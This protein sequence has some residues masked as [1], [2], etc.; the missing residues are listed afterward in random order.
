M[1]APSRILL[2]QLFSNGDCLYATSVARQIKLDYPGCHLTWA[3][4]DYCRNIIFNNPFID[5]ILVIEKI[6]FNNWEQHQK[7][8]QRWV[9]QLKKEGR[10]DK[11]V[12]PQLIGVNYSNY[13]QCIRSGIFRGYDRPITVPVQPV[14]SLTEEEKTRVREFVSQTDLGSYR[15]AILFEFAGRSGQSRL[16]ADTALSIADRVTR[17]LAVAVI[18]SSPVKVAYSNPSILDAG[19]LSLREIAY[20]SHYCHLLVGCSSGVTWVTTS[21]A[22]KCLNMIQVLDPN[23]YWFNSVVNDHKRFGLPVDHII[24][25]DDSSAERVYDCIAA[26]IAEGFGR[27]RGRYHS[28]FPIQFRITRGILCY[29]LGWGRVGAAIHHIRLNLGLYGF[30]PKLVKAIFLGLTTFPIV[31]YMNKRK[32]KRQ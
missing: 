14:L 7:E 10:F 21:D 11:I 8:F 9:R 12:F 23:A 17:E 26:V 1:N 24:E 29:L 18:L 30:K 4:A 6:N 16:S 19:H 22:G 25:M 28:D 13:D 32:T 20:L 31:N 3:I 2:I 15:H 5:D 27:A